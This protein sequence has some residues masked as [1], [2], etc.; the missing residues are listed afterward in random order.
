MGARAHRAHAPNHNFFRCQTSN[1]A[2]LLRVT[3]NKSARFEFRDRSP[4]RVLLSTVWERAPITVGLSA[5]KPPSKNWEYDVV[6][7]NTFRDLGS[8]P[9][10]ST[11]YFGALFAI[12]EQNHATSPISTAISPFREVYSTRLA[13]FKL[14][15]GSTHRRHPPLPYHRYYITATIRT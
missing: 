7:W 2:L 1:L 13:H 14:W 6:F 9:R 4:A 8:K 5:E 12:W 15:G 11:P 3:P 10:Y